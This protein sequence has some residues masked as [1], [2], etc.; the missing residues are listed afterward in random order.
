MH[1]FVARSKPCNAWTFRPTFF[2]A[3]SHRASASPRV[4]VVQSMLRS[5]IL[6][7]ASVLFFA[8]TA[9]AQPY[10]ARFVTQNVPATMIA[11]QQ[12]AVTVTMLNTGTDTWTQAAAYRL[13]SQN[14]QDNLTWG[15]GRVDV[16]TSVGP[17]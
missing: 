5:A 13:G 16:P 3:R 2:N 15:L 1:G 10:Q 8:P 4:S 6:L 7:I 11:G 9:Q 14:G 12:Y 17:S